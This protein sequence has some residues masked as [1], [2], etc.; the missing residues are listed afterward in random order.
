MAT[1]RPAHLPHAGDVA[2]LDG[3]FRH[4]VLKRPAERASLPA[5]LSA[6]IVQRRMLAFVQEV[7]AARPPALA[8]ARLPLACAQSVHGVTASRH[9]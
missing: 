6:P 1:H 9:T 5:L 4:M 2:S 8:C 7:G 3:L